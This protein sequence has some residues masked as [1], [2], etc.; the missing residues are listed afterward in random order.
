MKRELKKKF[1]PASYKQYIFPRL[2]NFKQEELTVEEYTAEFEHLMMK[3]DIVEPEEQTIARYLGGLRSEIC[4]VCL[5]RKIISLV[6]KANDEPVYDTYD[7]EENE[8]EQEEV[9]YGDQGEA[10]FVQRILKSTHVEDDKW[11]RHNIVHTWCTSHGKV[12]TVIIDSGSYENVVSTT[13]VE[14]LHFKVEPHPD[15]Y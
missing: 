11:L 9:T 12:C 3:C 7:E 13:M 8:V 14:K 6:E 4:N 5:N 2:Y 1:L 10:L 15:P